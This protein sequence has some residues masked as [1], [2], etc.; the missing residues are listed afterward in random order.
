MFAVMLSE[1]V[2]AGAETSKIAFKHLGYH[3]GRWLYLIDAYD[4]IEKDL[5]HR[6]YNPLVL[7]FAYTPKEGTE[8]FRKRIDEDIR[9]NLYYSLSE[10]SNAFELIDFKKNRNLL[11]N[12]IYS[13]LKKK[14]EY[15]LAKGAA[16]E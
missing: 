8:A 12:I 7:R 2:T 1:L 3:I 4:D 14:T 10:A 15:V 9:F 11:E 16:T 5:K 6:S 13:G